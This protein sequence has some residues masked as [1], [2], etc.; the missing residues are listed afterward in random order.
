MKFV[1]FRSPKGEASYGLVTGYEVVDLGQSR[2]AV[3][4]LKDFLATA[5]FASGSIDQA[6]PRYPLAGL[7]LLP[8]IPNPGKIICV[9]LNYQDHVKETGRFRFRLSLVVPAYRHFPDLPSGA[10]DQGRR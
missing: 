10:A 2:P 6:G 9:G 7:S 8:V 3:P 1:S 5:E 4:T